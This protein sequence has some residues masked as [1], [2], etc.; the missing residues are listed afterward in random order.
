MNFTPQKP[1]TPKPTPQKPIIQKPTPKPLPKKPDLKAIPH[2][3]EELINKQYE[4]IMREAQTRNFTEIA[5]ILN[6][7]IS[8]KVNYFTLA[9]THKISKPDIMKSSQD[10]LFTSAQH[11]LKDL[12]FV[13]MLNEF[14]DY[15]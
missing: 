3:L 4:M 7:E 6:D 5:R 12:R 9:I 11:L 8:R 2:T 10:E 15:I 1:A 14:P 13:S